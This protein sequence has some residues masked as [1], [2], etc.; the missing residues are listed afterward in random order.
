MISYIACQ[1]FIGRLDNCVGEMS[2]YIN[3]GWSTVVINNMT[4]QP[5][6]LGITIVFEGLFLS[7]DSLFK[8]SLYKCGRMSSRH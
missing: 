6:L 8:Q 7:R 5:L 2:L 1:A 4:K 3:S